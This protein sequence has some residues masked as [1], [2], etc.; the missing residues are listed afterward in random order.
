[1]ARD[2]PGERKLAEQAPQAFLVMPHV[3]I[4]LRVCVLEIR[5][6]DDGRPAVA[7][8]GDEDRVEVALANRAVQVDVEKVEARRRPPVAEESR[9]H[10]LRPQRL[11]KK[12]IVEQ[13]DLP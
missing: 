11:P 3:R 2:A 7:G 13:V 4:E 1:M 12:R 5:L 8:T 10:V 9:L 6:R